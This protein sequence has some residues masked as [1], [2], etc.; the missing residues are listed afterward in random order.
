MGGTG[1]ARGP[2]PAQ[3][4]LLAAAPTSAPWGRGRENPEEKQGGKEGRCLGADWS[5]GSRGAEVPIV[6]KG[7]PMQ[8][9]SALEASGNWGLGR[10]VGLALDR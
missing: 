8:A 6:V 3:R 1:C 2:A 4:F 7:L 10:G 5:G 9:S